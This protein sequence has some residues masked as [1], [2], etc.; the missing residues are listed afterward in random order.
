MGGVTFSGASSK[1]ACLD[2][3]ALATNPDKKPL[4]NADVF[5]RVRASAFR[6]DGRSL[7]G[8]GGSWG[9]ERVEVCGRGVVR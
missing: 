2:I 8:M 3:S 9:R 6:T 1:A 5:G 4:Y 7:W